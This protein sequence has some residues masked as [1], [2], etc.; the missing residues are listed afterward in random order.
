MRPR[1]SSLRELAQEV[2]AA[3]EVQATI[4]QNVNPLRLEVRRSVH[5]ADIARLHKVI[6][7]KQVLLVRADL[8][9]MRSDDALVLFRVVQTL[10]VVQIT[11]V[12][13]RNVVSEREREV[14]EVAVVG[15]IGVDSEIVAR[16]WTKIKEEFCDALFALRVLTEGVDDPDLAWTNG[17]SKSSGLRVSGDELDVLD[18][19][20][21]RDGNCGND[22]ART[23]FPEAK[24]VG[25][26][27]AGDT[28]G[29]Q[30]GDRHNKV[31]CQDDVLLEIDGKAM[32]AELLAKDVEGRGNILGPLVNDVEVGIGLNEATGRSTDSRAHVGDE[33]A[34]VG[35]G[36][37]LIGDGG[38]QS[39]VRL[40]ELGLVWV[41]GVK[42]VCRVLQSVSA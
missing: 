26:L 14:C 33:E 38:E 4:W 15:D 40:L 27:D 28:R 13:R 32:R 20:A 31:R 36:A 17:C 41:R 1:S 37:D 3:V 12:Q 9:V 8:D 35:L 21:V 24:R 19:S 34:T 42:V 5:D 22:L 39:T 7:N 11:D 16:A 18:A 6:R 10:H 2:N 29:L 25:F 30:D 23:E